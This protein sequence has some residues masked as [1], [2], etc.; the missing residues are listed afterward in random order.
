MVVEGI[1]SKGFEGFLWGVIRIE[2]F[3]VGM[4]KEVGRGMG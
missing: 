1:R 3:I 2:G 4:R